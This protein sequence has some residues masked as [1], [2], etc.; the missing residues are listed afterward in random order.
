MAPITLADLNAADE[1]HFV[2]LVAPLFEGAPAW[3][4]RAWPQRPFANVEALHDALTGTMMRAGRDEQVA[5][6]AAH[7]DL[8]GR[9]ALAGTLSADST[10][11]QAAAGLDRLSAAEVATFGERNAAYRARFGFPFVI[12]ARA[13]KKDAILSGLQTRLTHTRDQEIATALREIAKIVW[14]RLVDRVGPA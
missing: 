9:A 12:C 11:E 5:L 6:I 14:L 1:A 3:V 4:S 13:N 2:A 8:V 10:Q 7:P